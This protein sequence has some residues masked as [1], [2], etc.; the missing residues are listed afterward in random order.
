MSQAEHPIRNIIFDLGGVLVDFW[1][2]HCMEELGFSE[3]AKAAFRAQIF[4]GLWESCDRIPYE[5][6]EVRALFKEAV[7]G[8]EAE[9]D[10]LWDNVSLITHE[11]DYTHAWLSDLKE[12][13]FHL[14]VLSNYGKRAFEI[15]SKTY[16]FWDLIDGKLISY[17]VET[18]KPDAEIYRMICEKYSLQ[19]E[20]SVFVDDRECNVT[21]AK[22]LGFEGI[23]FTGYPK[24]EKEL[25]QICGNRGKKA[26]QHRE[27][28]R[29][30]RKIT[31]PEEIR[32]I[33]RE[34]KILHLGLFDEDY[35]YIVPMHYG[36]SWTDD[37]LTFYLHCAH[38]GHKLDLIRRSPK[39]CIELEC[40]VEQVS[41]G[42]DPCRYG[43]YYTSFIGRGLAKILTDEAEK[44]TGLKLL[45]K[46]QTGREFEF[47]SR[48]T[49]GVEVIRVTIEQYSAKARKKAQNSVSS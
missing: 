10:R 25:Q 19:P 24:A 40:G 39:V 37:A 7:P 5:D 22:A 23:V 31:D 4:S 17:E 38:A 12:R 16:D 49:A 21:A 6:A 2:E 20:E 11:R 14:Y 47:D 8:F 15:N 45:M 43:S 28:R 18:V 46:H 42:D 9:V 3:E 29:K 33:I 41:G 1:P 48:M 34:A 30:D 13:G 36:Y 26:L 35:P 27:M 32:G 44:R